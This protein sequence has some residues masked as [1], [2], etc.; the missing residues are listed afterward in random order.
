MKKFK[1]SVERALIILAVVIIAT[2]IVF[3]AAILAL[4]AVAAVVGLTY[5]LYEEDK[6]EKVSACVWGVLYIRCISVHMYNF[7]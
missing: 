1:Q 7:V 2:S 4:L 5:K 6:K 3:A